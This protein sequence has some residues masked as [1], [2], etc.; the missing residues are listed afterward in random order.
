MWARTGRKQEEWTQITSAGGI[1]RD[2]SSFGVGVS[3][4][5]CAISK[6][7]CLALSG[8]TFQ[9]VGPGKA[10]TQ[11]QGLQFLIAPHCGGVSPG[12]LALLVGILRSTLSTAVCTIVPGHNVAAETQP[13][14]ESWYMNALISTAILPLPPP[15]FPFK[16][17][18]STRLGNH[19]PGLWQRGLLI[20][21]EAW[22]GWSRGASELLLWAS[23][24]IG[25]PFPYTL[26]RLLDV[27]VL[28]PAPGMMQHII[29]NIGMHRP[30][31]AVHSPRVESHFPHR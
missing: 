3:H 19:L 14:D 9:R 15:F 28:F 29:W 26:L 31:S 2:S 4:V 1:V 5:I 10:H 20:G 24:V 16:N 30:G 22:T 23:P 6:G 13:L 25:V 21:V 11:R 18:S 12:C 17:N 27:H 7:C 8:T